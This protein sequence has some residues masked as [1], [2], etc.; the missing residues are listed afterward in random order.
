M[1]TAVFIPAYKEFFKYYLKNK[2]LKKEKIKLKRI[3]NVIDFNVL[4]IAI[5]AAKGE[6]YG[7]FNPWTENKET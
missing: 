1:G 7:D 3:Y 5:L 2:L 4:L 6:H